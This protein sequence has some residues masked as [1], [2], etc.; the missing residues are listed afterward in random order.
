MESKFS[1][2]L[3]IDIYDIGLSIRTRNALFKSIFRINNVKGIY[4]TALKVGDIK[5]L[6]NIGPKAEQEIN[7]ALEKLGLPK[8]TDDFSTL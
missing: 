6:R 7:E 5:R 1:K 3:N 8:L 4:D 2:R